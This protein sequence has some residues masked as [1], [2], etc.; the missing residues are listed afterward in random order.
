M[1][2]SSDAVS[3]IILVGFGIDDFG[4][5]FYFVLFLLFMPKFDRCYALQILLNIF[6]C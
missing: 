4:Y 6:G 3:Y 2:I 1:L 5:I